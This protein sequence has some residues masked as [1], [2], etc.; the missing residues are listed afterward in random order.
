MRYTV[1]SLWEWPESHETTDCFATR[2][3]ALYYAGMC[4]RS[5]ALR[6][7]VGAVACE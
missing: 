1:W 4:C 3:E 7:H 2:A 5:G 6:C